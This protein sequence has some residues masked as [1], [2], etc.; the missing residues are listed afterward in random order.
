MIG[1]PVLGGL[2]IYAYYAQSGCG[3]LASN[4]I[5][6]ENQVHIASLIYKKSF[7]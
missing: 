3:P 5:E 7:P 2:A 4:E 6:D 1:L